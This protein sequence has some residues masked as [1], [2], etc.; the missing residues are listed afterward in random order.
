MLNRF[1]DIR[2]ALKSTATSSTQ[3]DPA[4][5]SLFEIAVEQLA[6]DT[7]VAPFAT[8]AD[9]LD[10][11]TQLTAFKDA[12]AQYGL[13]RSLLAFANH[14]Q[15]LSN[16]IPAIPAVLTA[17][18]SVK[19]SQDVVVAV[20]A[21][22]ADHLQMLGMMMKSNITAV[23]TQSTTTKALHTKTSAQLAVLKT[24]MAQ[25]QLNADQLTS[26]PMKLVACETL[27]AAIGALPQIQT[28]L[29]LITTTPIPVDVA[30]YQI[31]SDRLRQSV[32]VLTPTTG[33]ALDATGRAVV[34]TTYPVNQI[35]TLDALG[36]RD[37]A[38]FEQL[39][40]AVTDG[41]Q[42]IDQLAA[43]NLKIT[44]TLTEEHYAN[45]YAM[46]AMNLVG[47]MTHRLAQW[48]NLVVSHYGTTA[49]IRIFHCSEVAA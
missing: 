5:E 2:V 49:L 42:R 10:T 31:W 6:G 17:D 41:L 3:L 35:D 45:I 29:D 40:T 25:R 48:A 37:M 47:G 23:N 13:T 27:L 28:Q 20:E 44:A 8:V 33:V 38:A 16:A 26:K 14:D 39:F 24:I 19:H 12:V 30:S 22:L 15:T 9:H 4:L 18:R 36:Y 21:A 7:I 32:A 46:E 11:I 1:T 34:G 43:A